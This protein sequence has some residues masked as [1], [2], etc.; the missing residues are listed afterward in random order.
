MTCIWA[1]LNTANAISQYNAGVLTPRMWSAILV[2]I[3]FAC[4][5]FYFGVKFLDRINRVQFLRFV[6]VVLFFVGAN[7][8]ISSV[9]A[10]L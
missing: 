2:G 3:P 4:V 10:V 6:Y 5:G 7:M 9:M 1:I 8:L